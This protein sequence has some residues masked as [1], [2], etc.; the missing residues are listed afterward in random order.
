M[1]ET[2][3]DGRLW[4]PALIAL[5]ALL[6][7]LELG[8]SARNARRLRARGGV[9]AGAAHYPAMV[10][11]HAGFLVSAPLEVF[12][13]GRSFVPAVGVP[14]LGLFAATMALRY[15]AIASLGE[16]WCTRVIAPPGGGL[17]TSGPYRWTR[18]PNY[19]AVA[20]EIPALALVHSAWIT[21]LSF[22]ILNGMLLRT[23]IRVEDALLGRDAG[24]GTARRA[25]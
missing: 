11:L 9:E 1:Q 23:R 21:A 24:T 16:R 20:I 25:K 4:Y 10:A 15:W 22:G 17:V 18:H 14:M 2:L 3:R 8:W 13:A 5:V 7:L 12:L 6:R 19:L